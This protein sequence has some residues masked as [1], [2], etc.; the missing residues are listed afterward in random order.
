LRHY[1]QQNICI[2]AAALP[3]TCKRLTRSQTLCN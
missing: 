1:A 3:D 2:I